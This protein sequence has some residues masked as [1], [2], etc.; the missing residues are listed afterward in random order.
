MRRLDDVMRT[1]EDSFETDLKALYEA[2]KVHSF[3]DCLLVPLQSLANF[4]LEIC[5]F[6]TGLRISEETFRV[7]HGK[8]AQWRGQKSRDS[9]DGWLIVMLT[10]LR[11]RLGNWNEVASQETKCWEN[12]LWHSQQVKANVKKRKVYIGNL[13]FEHLVLRVISASSEHS[14]LLGTGRMVWMLRQRALNQHVRSP[15]RLCHAEFRSR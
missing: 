10:Q 14:V 13:E 11:W 2:S 5:C 8:E 12:I 6:C 1:R 3:F 9:P 4:R 15:S 7:T